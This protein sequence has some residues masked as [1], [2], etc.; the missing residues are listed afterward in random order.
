MDD[1]GRLP[2]ELEREG[3]GPGRVA[4]VQMH[5]HEAEE[6]LVRHLLDLK[7]KCLLQHAQLG[8]Q[9]LHMPP[10]LCRGESHCGALVRGPA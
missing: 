3:E 10:N 8:L 4:R 2:R 1:V 6:S 7:P 9:V 5:E